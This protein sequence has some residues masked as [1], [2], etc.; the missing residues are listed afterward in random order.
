[1]ILE[2]HLEDIGCV[3]GQVAAALPAEGVGVDADV[4]L[5]PNFGVTVLVTCMGL[6]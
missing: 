6:A 3:F 2:P 1:M 4:L 5:E